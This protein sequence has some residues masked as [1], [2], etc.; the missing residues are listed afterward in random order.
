MDKPVYIEK[1]GPDPDGL[2]FFSL[3]RE[4]ITHLQNLCGKAWTD[5]NLHDPGVTILEQLCYAL[6]DMAYRTEFDL[7]DYLTA[8][9]GSINFE[10]QALYR[11]Q[12]IFPSQP[13]TIN[14]YRKIF[15]DLEPSI[16]NVWIRTWDD[17]G[18]SRTDCRHPG[19]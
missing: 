18:V 10:R 7:A 8:K 11:P 17:R 16:N 12:D 6:T 19:Q 3:K 13:V 15:F 9:N 5:Y 1:I 14:D 4:G 2:D